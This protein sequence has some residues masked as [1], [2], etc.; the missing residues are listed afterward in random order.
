MADTPILTAPT[1]LDAQGIRL[2][3]W[4]TED[5]RALYEAARESIASVSPWLPWLHEGYSAEDSAR[6]I[7]ESQAG[8]ERGEARTFAIVDADGR[9]LGD[10]GLN[11]IDSK[12]RSANL[13]YWVRSSAQG[14]G[15]ATRAALALARYG[16][17]VL[18]LVRI[19]IV[20]A[21]DNTASRRT[22]E[23]LGAHFDGT[24]PNRI[25]LNG[26]AAAAAVY[27]LLPPEP[28]EASPG[29]VLEEGGLRL[30][31]FRPTDLPALHASLHE[32]MDSIGRWQGWC[33]PGFS[34]EDGRRWIARTR[35]AWH[36]VGDECAL[37]I[38]DRSTDE[39][40]G[41]VGLNHWQAENGMA[42]LGYWVRQSQQERGV[43]TAAVRLLARHALH[44]TELRRLEIVIA[45][46]NLASRSVAEKAGAQ[47]EG[48]A[49][50]RLTLRG[51]P[52]D[53]AIYS[54][55]ASDLA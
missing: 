40:I 27:S 48:I 29:P 2:R 4:R 22:A 38:A 3:P 54:L 50:R 35:L 41:S 43:A 53:A 13:G 37:V 23:R 12:R 36:G 5:A 9:V 26:A 55:V 34:M 49:R 39:L 18:G 25:L 11:R 24:S 31:P 51:E 44:A 1:E 19:E 6:W 7:A 45:A 30:R 17:E 47:F 32:S 21:V 14:Q 46:D 33:T 52:L 20:V 28:S 16:F 10:I 42:N 15:V 8:H